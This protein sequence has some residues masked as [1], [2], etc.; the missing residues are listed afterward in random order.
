MRILRITTENLASLAGRHTV[1]FTAEPLRSTG[2]FAIIGP[3]G[4]GKSTLLDAMCLALFHE[5]PRLQQA[6]GKTEVGSDKLSEG[7]S[8][9][10]LRRGTTSGLAE[11]AFVAVDGQT[12]TARWSLRRARGKVAGNL[13]QVATSLHR[14]DLRNN[15]QGEV[16]AAGKKTEVLAA[17][18]ERLGLNFKQFTRAVLLAQN[19]FSTFLRAPE[20]DRATILEALT[21]TS[22][23]TSI[24]KAVY[25][26]CADERQK[27][28]Q[29]ES[30]LHGQSPLTD[31]A[32]RLAEEQQKIARAEHKQALELRN[33]LE[34]QQ[35][36]H[37]RNNELQ[38]QL[39]EKQQQ[40][41]EAAK[42]H[43]D[44][45]PRRSQLSRIEQA[46]R[47][48][49]TLH[50]E[51]TTKTNEL[52]DRRTLSEQA[53]AALTRAEQEFS[54]AEQAAASAHRRLDEL[55]EK[56][57]P[58]R[59]NLAT[60]RRLD[61]QLE[62]A[63]TRLQERQQQHAAARKTLQEQQD[64][65]DETEHKLT[66]AR[67][68]E[69]K[70]RS[71]LAH[72]A[73]YQPLTEKADQWLVLLNQL[74]QNR[75]D[76]ESAAQR[77]A[78]AQSTADSK[79]QEL[80]EFRLGTAPLQEKIN[81]TES[82]L[83]Q[84][85]QQRSLFNGDQL[86]AQYKEALAAEQRLTQLL[87]ELDRRSE[88]Q[89]LFEKS[90][91]T[92]DELHAEIKRDE[93]RIAELESAQPNAKTELQDSQ[94]A[95]QLIRDAFDDHAKRFRADL[96]QGKA[97]PV[98]GSSEHPWAEHPPDGETLALQKAEERRKTAEAA[99][100]EI[101]K[102]LSVLEGQ[103]KTQIKQQKKHVKDLDDCRRQLAAHAFS[104]P[105]HPTIA[106]ILEL[107]ADA[108]IQAATTERN[109]QH[110]AKE[111]SDR[112]I[113]ELDS[114]ETQIRTLRLE[115]KAHTDERDS[116][117]KDE[118]SLQSES[119]DANLAAAAAVE[120][121]RASIERSTKTQQLLADFWSALPNSLASFNDNPRQF[122]DQLQRAVTQIRE[123]QTALQSGK[124]QIGLLEQQ[125]ENVT[126][127]LA[128]ETK[129]A[130]RAA[131]A[132]DSAQQE[133]D[134]LKTDRD[135]LL[136]GQTVAD[137][138]Q[139]LNHAEN[140]ARNSRDT[141]D[142][143]KTNAEIARSS[144]SATA[145]S[146]SKQLQQAESAERDARARLNSWLEAFF[147]GSHQTA[148]L[149]E[150]QSLLAYSTTWITSER[151]ELNH[152]AENVT[153][154]ES[155]YNVISS[156]RDELLKAPADADEDTVLAKLAQ[157]MIDV[158][159][160]EAAKNDAERILTN[161]DELRH[162]NSQLS[163]QIT[164]Q[165]ERFKPWEQLNACIGS[166]DGKKFNVI[167]QR[168]TLDL[169]L[170]HANQQLRQLSRRY[171]LERL[172]D[173]LNLA[174]IDQDLGD[175]QRSIHSLSGGETFLVSLGLALGLASLTSNRLRIES[176]F[177]DEGFG[178]LDEDT[179]EIAMNALNH[180]QSQGRKVGI[181]TH[182]E[183]MKDAIPVQIQV[184]KN[185]AGSSKIILPS[186]D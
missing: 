35:R 136:G 52:S 175:E 32:R 177:I 87:T 37:K 99:L 76:E 50:S 172:G 39:L 60:A 15:E 12:Y 78:A 167:A 21:D 156:Q 134:K 174:V 186:N 43:S 36:W 128:T 91:Q 27:V 122:I 101:Q 70:Q 131:T 67:E 28:E 168:Y 118:A 77:S 25:Q 71:E 58:L 94:S 53:A 152:L 75:A 107:P 10:L 92:H 144:A 148:A 139:Q 86:R 57:E 159:S 95:V 33:A 146:N 141:A 100:N 68:T 80:K 185:A 112:T 133:F 151:D 170:R 179:L 38:Q 55:L 46:Q 1:D 31:D 74:L 42:A 23:F 183:R 169:L 45:A 51:F 83:Q 113:S 123:L 13:Q 155:A 69:S 97:C 109:R 103:N 20:G 125:L 181:I 24:S 157:Q 165:R 129:A 102:E 145:A 65:L 147:P 137:F 115:L 66:S 114:I 56:H 44:A 108:R 61:D 8:R 120:A 149:T 22:H 140:T 72:F 121:C 41:D 62:P 135:A 104:D 176:L 6:P 105:E 2:L 127:A 73:P 17:V 9:N 143:D 154:S 117:A 150:L 84:A 173:T 64:L 11:V 59:T 63:R 178:S 40:R 164:Q 7:D 130:D 163:E 79:L 85:D 166:A 184:R 162:K 5:T 90:Q 48:A 29:L 49:A 153:K 160:A 110:S 82:R 171:R 106:A 132:L 116:R 26:R 158:Q 161:D 180:L 30:Q 138:E 4:S 89:R 93:R 3:T 182:V 142:R 14:D 119:N 81:H 88:L 54:T 19:E 34:E 96:Q 98:C 47:E 16:V 18:E 124:N 111:E 126:T